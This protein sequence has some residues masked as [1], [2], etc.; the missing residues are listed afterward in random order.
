MVS[1]AAALVVSR[2]IGVFVGGHGASVAGCG[3]S[4]QACDLFW[5]FDG[6]AGPLTATA[7]KIKEPTEVVRLKVGLIG[8][9]FEGISLDGVNLYSTLLL[10]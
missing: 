6:R 3:I 4:D 2:G 10:L 1:A 7:G 5:R 9:T 8:P